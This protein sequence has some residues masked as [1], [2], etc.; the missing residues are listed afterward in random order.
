V[1][2]GTQQSFYVGEANVPRVDEHHGMAGLRF[3]GLAACDSFYH[4]NL[5]NALPF[6]PQ[7]NAQ[8]LGAPVYKLSAR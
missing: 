8:R 3:G 6:K 4:G 5:M 7:R 1:I 2:S